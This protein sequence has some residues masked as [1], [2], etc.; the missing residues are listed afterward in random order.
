MR[1]ALLLALLVAPACFAPGGASPHAI[2]MVR[3]QAERDLDC[4]QSEIRIIQQV[5]GRFKAIGCGRKAVYFGA[6]DNL[7]CEVQP[8][9][10]AIP[11]HDRP[12]PLTTRP[13]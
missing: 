9:D 11:W 8:E 12:D 10:K 2:P 7:V 6:C 4:P 5:G 1:C 13:R 3:V